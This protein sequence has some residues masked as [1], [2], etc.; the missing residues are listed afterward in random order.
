MANKTDS[1]TL[2]EP[3]VLWSLN[4]LSRTLGISGEFAL[5]LVEEGILEPD[6]KEPSSWR[7]R[8]VSVKR[9]RCALRLTQD[10]GVNLSG[11]ALALELLE[12]IDYLRS[13]LQRFEKDF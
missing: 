10:L 6:G 13:R 11:A 3:Q 12:E 8:N 5:A 7:F 1:K 2:A 4:E 9:A